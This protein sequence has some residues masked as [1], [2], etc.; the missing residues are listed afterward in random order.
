VDTLPNQVYYVGAVVLYYLFFAVVE[1]R[2]DKAVSRIGQMLA[3]MTVTLAIGLALSATQWVPSLELLSY[4][5]RKIVGSELGYVY[6]PPWY[7]MTW[8]FPI[9][10][11]KPMM[12]SYLSCL[13]RWAYHMTISSIWESPH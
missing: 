3:M 11:E 4:S 1:R 9:Y 12:R 10:L 6:L 2:A 8:F 5:N 13:P 7:S